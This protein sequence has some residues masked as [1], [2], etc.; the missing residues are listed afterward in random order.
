MDELQVLGKINDNVGEMSEKTIETFNL[1][2]E[3]IREENRKKRNR[4]RRKTIFRIICLIGFVALSIYINAS[5]IKTTKQLGVTPSDL[6]DTMDMVQD[7]SSDYNSLKE[8]ENDLFSSS[9]EEEEFIKE[10]VNEE[11][12]SY[13]RNHDKE[14]LQNYVVDEMLGGIDLN[15]LAEMDEEELSNLGTNIKMDD[16][17]E[18]LL[19][20]NLENIETQNIEDKDFSTDINLNTDSKIDFLIAE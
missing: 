4:K 15:E 12:L 16:V 17:G 9:E 7:I 2:I 18:T 10:Y 11:T 14:G 13:I 8:M 3:D 5:I 20:D 19:D 6:K 1:L